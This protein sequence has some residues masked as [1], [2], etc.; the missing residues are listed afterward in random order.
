[1]PIYEQTYRTWDG[2]LEDHPKT[3]WVITKTGIQLLWRK[4]MVILLLF[5]YLSFFVRAVQIYVIARYGEKLEIAQR[6]KGLKIDSDF[7]INYL[8]GQTFFLLLILIFA[9]AGLIAND[10]K[11][12]AL[13]IYFSKPVSFW[14]YIIGKFLIL[15]FFGSLI[16]FVPSLLLFVI[17]I[18]LAQDIVYFQQHF[19]IPFSQAGYVI[20]ALLAYGSIILVLS[21]SS[22][23]TRSAAISFFARIMFPDLIRTILSRISLVGLFSITANIKQAGSVLFNVDRPYGFPPI[24]ALLVV[25]M[26]TG[27]CMVIMKVRVRPTEVVK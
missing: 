1:M 24:Y 23:G 27:V 18:V 15:C 2:A 14:D 9:G 6:L 20:L 26:V 3:W 21:A 13:S 8:N 17:R 25:L 11:F 4:G 12:K 5:S 10:K 7:Y 19:W 22:K 16:T